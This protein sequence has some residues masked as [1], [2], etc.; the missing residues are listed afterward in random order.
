V[1]DETVDARV[2]VRANLG[3][4]DLGRARIDQFAEKDAPFLVMRR[5]TLGAELNVP[6]SSMTVMTS[7]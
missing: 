1:A 5:I 4:Q 6:G 2:D 7:S 3:F